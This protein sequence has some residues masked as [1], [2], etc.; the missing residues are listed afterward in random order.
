MHILFFIVCFLFL[1]S[2]L[3][4]APVLRKSCR[5]WVTLETGGSG[6][7]QREE[8]I[9]HDGGA[10]DTRGG[11]DVE[12]AVDVVTE[13]ILR[14]EGRSDMSY[15]TDNNRL[16]SQTDSFLTLLVSRFSDSL[17]LT[18][19]ISQDLCSVQICRFVKSMN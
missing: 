3:L 13:V 4:S 15:N 6:L 11:D 12:D 18:G 10:A 17:S 7:P 5:R 1:I 19:S 14:R 16:Q 9:T 2:S 8:D